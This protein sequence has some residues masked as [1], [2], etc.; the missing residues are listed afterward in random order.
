MLTFTTKNLQKNSMQLGLQA[1]GGYQKYFNSFIG[2]SYYGYFGFRY[3]YMG[4]DSNS[5]TD[6]NRYSLGIGGNL[7]FNLY[8][9]IKKPKVGRAKIQAYGLFA[10]L[11]GIVNFWN[12][13]F[14]GDSLIRHNANLDATFGFSIRVDKFKWSLGT[15]IPIIDDVRTMRSGGNSLKLMDNYKSA[16]LFMN[17]TTFF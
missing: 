13:N 1:Q 4:V 14:I 10:G 2:M 8:S 6:L 16:D 15:H 5:L 9:K 17:F 3:L 7:L 11:L 12:A